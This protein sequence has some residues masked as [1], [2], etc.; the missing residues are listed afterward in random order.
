MS[1][2]AKKGTFERGRRILIIGGTPGVNHDCPDK[3]VPVGL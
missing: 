2:N 3:L 1:N